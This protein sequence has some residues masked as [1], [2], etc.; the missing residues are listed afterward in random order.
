MQVSAL[1]RVFPLVTP[2]L[3]NSFVSEFDDWQARIDDEFISIQKH[4]D[5]APPTH[6]SFL[7]LGP[8]SKTPPW[9][10]HRPVAQHAFRS[11]GARIRDGGGVGSPLVVDPERSKFWPDP[12]AHLRTLLAWS[13][14]GSGV[15]AC[16]GAAASSG[17]AVSVGPAVRSGV[18]LL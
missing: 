2:E 8:P 1:P 7:G 9:H 14:R 18:T 10:R 13:L 5:L 12:M 16:V 3:Q 17:V 15:G 11:D 6:T 4:F